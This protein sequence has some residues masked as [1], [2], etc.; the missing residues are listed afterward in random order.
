V[1]QAPPGTLLNL[2]VADVSMKAMAQ[3]IGRLIGAPEKTLLI[4]LEE[5]RKS[6]PFADG[7]ASDQRVDPRRA[8]ELLGWRPSAPGLEDEIENGSYRAHVAAG[9]NASASY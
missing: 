3:A 6:V 5:A 4:P 8:I 9:A 2:G 7:I 1:E